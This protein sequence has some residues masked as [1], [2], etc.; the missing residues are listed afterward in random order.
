MNTINVNDIYSNGYEPLSID[1]QL[2]SFDN[3]K[4]ILLYQ[5]QVVLPYILENG[6]PDVLVDFIKTYIKI[7]NL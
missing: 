2:G 5:K 6:N 4:H 7:M 3:K 1:T